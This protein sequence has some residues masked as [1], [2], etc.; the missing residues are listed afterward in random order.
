MKSI[1]LGKHSGL[2]DSVEARSALAAKRK[3]VEIT[4]R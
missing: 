2:I 3:F 1:L 4:K